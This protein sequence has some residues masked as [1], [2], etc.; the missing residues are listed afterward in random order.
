MISTSNY[1]YCCMIQ[2]DKLSMIIVLPN[3]INGLKELEENLGS[4]S[5][6]YL[7]QFEVIT[8]TDIYLPKFKIESSIDLSD[9]LSEVSSCIYMYYFNTY[10]YPRLE[11]N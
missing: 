1:I 2:G 5:L 9:I 3:E 10:L 11:L 4:L 7:K 6:K 8:N